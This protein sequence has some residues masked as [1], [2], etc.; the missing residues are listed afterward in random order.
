LVTGL[1]FCQFNRF[2]SFF[3]VVRP[4]HEITCAQCKEKLPKNADYC[5][6]CGNPISDSRSSVYGNDQ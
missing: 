2:S 1:C 4:Q 6:R 5:L 3:D